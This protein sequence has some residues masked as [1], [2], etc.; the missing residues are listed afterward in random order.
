MTTRADIL[1]EAH[2]LTHGDRLEQYGSPAEN[3]SRIA[4]GWSE[5]FGTRIEPHQVC[6]A[7][8]WLKLC[9]L[10]QDATAR[11][12][13]VDLA[14]YASLGGELSSAPATSP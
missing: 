7:M 12:G 2:D 4:A 9:R 5:I 13:W 3:F 10:M 6:M 1:K 14:G 11:D 8:S